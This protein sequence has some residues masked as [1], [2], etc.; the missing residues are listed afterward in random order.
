MTV[1]PNSDRTTIIVTG[2][3]KGSVATITFPVLPTG[4]VS[5]HLPGAVTTT[6]RVLQMPLNPVPQGHHPGTIDVSKL[7]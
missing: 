5:V 2:L 4:E 7:H 1:L 6:V 3:L